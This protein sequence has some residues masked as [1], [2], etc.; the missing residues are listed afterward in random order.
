[1]HLRWLILCHHT[2]VDNA[3][4]VYCHVCCLC[5]R[6]TSSTYDCCRCA[7]C[8]FMT[9][10]SSYELY[11]GR[12]AFHEENG[13][14]VSAPQLKRRMNRH[15]CTVPLREQL[16]WAQ[17]NVESILQKYSHMRKTRFGNL[18]S[19]LGG[20]GRWSKISFLARRATDSDS[21]KKVR[22]NPEKEHS[23]SAY[24]M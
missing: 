3:V 1:M 13:E 5:S 22:G 4:Y 18:S 15:S 6:S 11:M 7:R 12:H 19:A 9:R 23:A 21:E 14:S 16:L 17:L 10:S 24:P 20:D 2:S 8:Q